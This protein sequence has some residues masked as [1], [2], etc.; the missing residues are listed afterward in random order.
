VYRWGESA[1]AISVGLQ[2]VTNGG[3]TESLFRGGFMQS[4]APTTPTDISAGQTIYNQIVEET[5]C[6][7]SG[8]TLQCLRTVPFDTFMA[9]VNK[10][11]DNFNPTQASLE[12]LTMPH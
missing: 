1:G 11:P 7:S 2:L 12:A 5:R 6:A 10:T 3:N 9:A 4:G 8:D